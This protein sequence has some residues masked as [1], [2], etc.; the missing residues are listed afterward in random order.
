[1]NVIGAFQQQ[2]ALPAPGIAACR[3][4]AAQASI[5]LEAADVGAHQSQPGVGHPRKGGPAGL[6]DPP[7]KAPRRAGRRMLDAPKAEAQTAERAGCRRLTDRTPPKLPAPAWSAL[8][9]AARI[10]TRSR[11]A[12]D[13]LRSMLRTDIARVVSACGA[14]GRHLPRRGPILA[15]TLRSPLSISAQ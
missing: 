13:Q 14:G 8:Q 10:V 9:N 15:G 4:R 6:P 7:I 1:V 11:E 3:G 2:T 5:Q 12:A